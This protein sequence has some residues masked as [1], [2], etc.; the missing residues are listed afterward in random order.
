MLFKNGWQHQDA[1]G[2]TNIL[3]LPLQAIHWPFSH[4]IHSQVV[5]RRL[6]DV[7]V[8]GFCSIVQL[9][10]IVQHCIKISKMDFSVF[11]RKRRLRVQWWWSHGS[12]ASFLGV[13]QPCNI[14]QHSATSATISKFCTRG[15][16]DL[17]S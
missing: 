7:C 11:R 3:Q 1:C 17:L 5:R 9:R 4:K 13:I 14:L 12:P 8:T 2:S 6:R 15:F 10:G 16:L